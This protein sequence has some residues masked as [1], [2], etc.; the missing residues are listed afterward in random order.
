MA[1]SGAESGKMVDICRPA[2]A[3]WACQYEG[4]AGA[5]ADRGRFQHGIPDF[6]K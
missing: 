2:V 6:F 3:E 1:A 5:K 4:T